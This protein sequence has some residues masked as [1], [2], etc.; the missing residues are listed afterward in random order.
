MYTY[1]AGDTGLT[2]C[3]P[4]WTAAG[5]KLFDN[6]R[7]PAARAKIRAE[8]EGGKYEWENLCALSEP[9][10]VLIVGT[11][12]PEN[13]KFVGQRLDAIAR[14][15]NKDW[16]DAA[17]DLIAADETRVETVYFMMSEDNVKM[18]LRLPWIK[19]GTDAGGFDPANA[20]D[21]VHPRAYGNYPRILG[22][23]VREEEVLSLEEAVRKASSAVARRLS[24]ADR[25][26][27]QEGAFAD[28]VL[29]DPDKIADRAAF[30]NPHQLSTGMVH[31]LVNGVPVIRNGVHTGA[32]PG[33]AIRGPGWSGH[34][35]STY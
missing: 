12:K 21:M 34:R 35:S 14:A 24:I 31:V 20:R 6:L 11:R 3:L 25:G 8:I 4:P 9:E 33:R 15:S 28:L 16:I 5:G 23:Y 30:E 27:I 19:F 22:K 32:K 18:Q 7:D 17:M 26:L 10:N 1:T 29:F 13:K 2:A